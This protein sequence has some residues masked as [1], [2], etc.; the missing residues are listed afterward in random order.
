MLVLEGIFDTILLIILGIM[1]STLVTVIGIIFIALGNKRKR[2]KERIRSRRKK[3]TSVLTVL[4]SAFLC[5]S[6]IIYG[7]MAVYFVVKHISLDRTIEKQC[8]IIIEAVQNK[9]K[10]PIKELF[11]EN[12][13]NTHDLD[14]ELDTFINFIDGNIVSYNDSY[15]TTGYFSSKKDGLEYSHERGYIY[16]IQTDTGNEYKIYVHS[17]YVCEKDSDFVGIIDL[18]IRDYNR[19]TEENHYPEDAYYRIGIDY[20]LS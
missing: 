19:F 9:E 16:S 15:G 1:I 3:Y 20:P 13:K 6:F 5:I 17:F 14:A 7:T 8:D 12:A 2:Y 10:E 11:C 4:G 18:S